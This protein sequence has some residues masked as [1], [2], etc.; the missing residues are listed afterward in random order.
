MME[1]ICGGIAA[2][3]ALLGSVVGMS[4][5]RG[6]GEGDKTTSCSIRV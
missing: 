2:F 6:R 5:R 3:V 1:C 4:C